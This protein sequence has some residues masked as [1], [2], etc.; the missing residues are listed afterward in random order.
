MEKPTY[1]PGTIV[2]SAYDITAGL[3]DFTLL[4]AK[5]TRL[6]VIGESG[7]GL[8][9]IA[10]RKAS[11]PNFEFAVSERDIKEPAPQELYFGG[12]THGE[13]DALDKWNERHEGAALIHVG[14]F[15]LG[16]LSRGES[17]LFHARQFNER[18]QGKGNTLYVIRGNHDDPRFFQHGDS[19]GDNL[20]LVKDGT[21][22]E[23]GGKRIYCHGGAI[24]VDRKQ[25]VPGHS[26]WA[27]EHCDWQGDAEKLSQA[28]IVVTHGAGAWSELGV[29]SQFLQQFYTQDPTLRSE[30]RAESAVFDAMR[31]A[32]TSATHWFYGHFHRS[33]R[34]DDGKTKFRGLGVKEIVQ[35][36]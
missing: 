27:G 4:A 32:A 29:D 28:D 14:D 10:V 31:A 13:F 36:V 2:E 12:D 19:I 20:H 34:H 17:V 15:G 21:L 30:L 9:P 11:D 25:R 22:L 6:I 24:S 7:N 35:L 23:L 1:K 33:M 3:H 5:G 18:L 26:W 16:F 8:H